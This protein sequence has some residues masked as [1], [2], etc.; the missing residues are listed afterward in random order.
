MTMKNKKNLRRI[1]NM[2]SDNNQ[3]VRQKL[4]FYKEKYFE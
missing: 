4:K 1:K 2:I 3:N